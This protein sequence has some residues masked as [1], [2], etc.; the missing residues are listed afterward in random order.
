MCPAQPFRFMDLPTEIR[1]I[2]YDFALAGSKHT[3][4]YRPRQLE[5]CRDGVETWNDQIRVENWN[6]QDIIIR[7]IGI[8]MA[9]KTAWKEAMPVFYRTNHFYYIFWTLIWPPKSSAVIPLC[10]WSTSLHFMQYV[11]MNCRLLGIEYLHIT[12]VSLILRLAKGIING[13]PNLRTFT[14][15]LLSSHDNIRLPPG[16]HGHV[17]I[18]RE[19]AQELKIST[20]RFEDSNYCMEYIRIR[21]TWQH[22]GPTR[23]SN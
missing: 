9:S 13:C 11:S 8:L 6:D 4:L 16:F 3:K 15:Q 22:S 17:Q 21:D 5:E 12:R 14:L 2:I 18:A 23:S 1:L 20:D 7:N 19:I 10:E